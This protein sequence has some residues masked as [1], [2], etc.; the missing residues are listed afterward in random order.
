MIFRL[1]ETKVKLYEVIV[2][3]QLDEYVVSFLSDL[4]AKKDDYGAFYSIARSLLLKG[5]NTTLT[6]C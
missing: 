6:G 5:E 3:S 1:F 4:A 2:E